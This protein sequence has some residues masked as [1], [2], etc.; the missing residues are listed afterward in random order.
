MMKK[1][2][3]CIPAIVLATAITR[4]QVPAYAFTPVSGSY[5]PITGGTNVILTYNAAANYDDGIATPANAVPIGFNFNYNGTVYT[6]IRPC[7]N[8]FAAFGT[9]ALANNT[10]DW[11]NSLTNG[12][13]ATIRPLI[14]PLWDDLDMGAVGAVTYLLSGIAPNRVLTIQWAGAKWEFA[15]LSSVISFQVK[16]YETS[17]MIE[18]IYKQ[19]SGDIITGG[20]LG[21]SIGISAAGTG[22]GSFLSLSDAST[23]PTVS[24]TTESGNIVTKPATGQIYRF[25]PYCI[26]SATNTTGE[27]ISNFTYGSINNTSSSTAVFENFSNVSTTVSLTPTS[28]LPFSVALSSFDV[29]DQV[30]IFID[31]NHNGSFNDLG[32]TVFTST[33]PLA[34]GTVTGT[35]SVPAFS[36]TV[37]QGITRL[38]IRMHNTSTGANATSCGVSTNGQVEDYSVN[39]QPC[40]AG[41]IT[42]QP[43]NTF[44]CNNG[45]GTIS[46]STTGTGITYQ[47]QVS[48]NNGNSYN[49]LTNSGVYSGVT[50]STLLLTGVTPVMTSYR[51]RV[52]ISGTCTP[53]N[54]PSNSVLL[55]VN[56]AAAITA[57][58]VNHL[59]AC[60]GTSPS[61]AI[62]ASGSSPAY[63]WQVSTDGGINFTDI[64][65]AIS[66]TLALTNVTIA[67]NGDRYRNVV[68]VASCG[69]AVSSAVILTVNPLPVV[70][71]SVA[72]VSEIK[73]GEK[74]YVTTGSVAP[75]TSF[76]WTLNDA[77]IMGANTNQLMV[78]TDALGV[79]KVTV[80]DA[81]GCVASSGTAEVRPLLTPALFIYPNPTTGQFHV[82][83]YSPGLTTVRLFNS[84]GMMV[85]E[86]HFPI[87]FPITQYLDMQF[88]LSAMPKGI[89]FIR[90]RHDFTK[91]WNITGKV[92]VQ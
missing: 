76:A 90:V 59:Y 92:I 84:A 45:S 49:D 29:N 12:P 62:T 28:T 42:T 36:T 54:T 11:N 83:L 31:F 71:I 22:S 3:L 56:T 37:L 80:T 82:R 58:P 40:F 73:P 39:I 65:G 16:L 88:D 2:F 24:F 26:A 44:I 47:W 69:S 61:F 27:K 35:I 41:V 55:T 64:S 17:N 68:T 66:S 87:N 4:A 57:N 13:A 38:R 48:T 77:L 10:D 85:A 89:Y 78:T 63:Q 15:A 23:N 46:V 70:T 25:T 33:T 20:S 8:G 79:Y 60:V 75:G 1:I 74:T 81:N 50:S 30:V 7:A 32:E 43:S 52:L 6:T 5:T 21:A 67:A 14:A 51:Y 34:S 19:E 18:F 91:N 86:K 53:A 9:A 72:P